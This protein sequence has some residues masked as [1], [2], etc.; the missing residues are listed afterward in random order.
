MASRLKMLFAVILIFTLSACGGG[1]SVERDSTATDSDGSDTS[2]T[3]EVNLSIAD[4]NGAAV[5]ELTSTSPLVVTA[6]VTS[7][8]GDVEDQL[9]TFTFSQDGLASF[10]N[11]TGTALT[12]AQGVATIGLIVGASSGDGL[13]TGALSDGTEGQIGFSSSGTSQSGVTPA[14]L[15]LYASSIQLASSGSDEIELIAV[16]KNA[17]NIL[18]SGVDVS[19]AANNG[20]E[21]QIVQGTSADDGTAR[22]TLTS[23]NNPENR[24]ITATVSSGTL[25]E[26]IDVEIVGTE[27]N[28]DGPISVV[29]GDTVDLTI[30][31]VDSDGTGLANQSVQ[32]ST[33]QGSIVSSAVTDSEG[34]VAIQYVATTSGENLITASALNAEGSLTF[35]VQED[36]FSFSSVPTE[37]VPLNTSTTLEVTWLKDNIAYAGGEVTL[38]ASR[39]DFVS[40]TVVTDAN[41]VAAFSIQSNN[42]GLASVTANGVDANNQTVSARTQF[43]F[44]A[45]VPDTIIVDASPDLIGPD[46]QTSTITAIVRDVTGNLVKGKV[47]NFRVDDVSGGYVSPNS[48]TTDSNGIASTVYTSNA[49]SSEDAVIVH[50]EVADNNSITDFTTLTVGDR[51]FDISLGT[52]NLLSSP[53]DSSYSKEFSVFVSDSVGRPVANVALTASSTPIKY[54]D[55]EAFYQGFWTYDIVSGFWYTTTTK[56]CRNEDINGNGSLDINEDINEDDKLTPGIIGTISFVDGINETDENG[57]AKIEIRYPKAYGAWTNV[58][59][60]VFGQSSG[61]ESFESQTFL[62]PVA[63]EDLQIETAAPPA[64]PFGFNEICNEI[65]P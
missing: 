22:A 38:S 1:G 12:N 42:A 20:A 60:A 31:V 5:N 56:N 8:D 43:E 27:V 29:L 7:S 17:Q 6:T 61:S 45:T 23:R 13:V 41:G 64:N 4:Q 39:G 51:A 62:L 49:V 34:Q 63:S 24:T 50:A 14:S 65:T 21:L 37:D 2:V 57:Q 18:L 46:G 53:D 9:V 48:A 19:F 10:D 47:I 3:Y 15:E 40:S 25:S 58:N 36:S 11:D 59:I 35:T 54:A 16:V 44:I 30:K 28:V 52:G 32:L 33:T 26:T 55:G